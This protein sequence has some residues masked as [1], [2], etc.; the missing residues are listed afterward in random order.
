VRCAD[1]YIIFNRFIPAHWF[2]PFS[3]RAQQTSE[4]V[5]AIIG[6]GSVGLSALFALIAGLAFTSSGQTVLFNT[7]GHG[8]VL[9]V[10]SQASAYILMVCHY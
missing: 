6:V 4:N 5:A 1:E 8:S 10:L 2:Y 3:G 7:Y 9:A